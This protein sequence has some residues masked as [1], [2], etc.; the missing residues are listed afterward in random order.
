MYRV[1]DDLD[2]K[3]ITTP[4]DLVVGRHLAR[5]LCGGEPHTGEKLSEDDMLALER[6]AFIALC[7]TAETVARI[8]HMLSTGR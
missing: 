6:E 5:V 7:D 4:H 2:N 3:G 1:L 8:E